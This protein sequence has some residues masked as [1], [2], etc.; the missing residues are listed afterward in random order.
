MEAASHW[1]LS[2]AAAGKVCLMTDYCTKNKGVRSV[3]DP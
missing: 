3:P 2:E 1:G